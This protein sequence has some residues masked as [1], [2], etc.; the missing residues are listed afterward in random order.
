MTKI[1]KEIKQENVLQQQQKKALL[2][3]FNL[4][5]NRFNDKKKEMNLIKQS[6]ILF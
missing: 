3:M 6:V 5:M 4:Q 1:Y 2:K